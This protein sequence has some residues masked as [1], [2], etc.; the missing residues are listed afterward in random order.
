MIALRARRGGNASIEHN[1]CFRA[2][3]FW[4]TSATFGSGMYITIT[5][6]KRNA[7]VEKEGFAPFT[8][9]NTAG[10]RMIVLLRLSCFNDQG[11]PKS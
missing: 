1:T 3:A 7:Q 8:T 5:N 9:Q 11:K 2:A 4:R 10:G 6:T